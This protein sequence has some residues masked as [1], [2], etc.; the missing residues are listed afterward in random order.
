MQRYR[1]KLTSEAFADRDEV[2][3]DV[4]EQPTSKPGPCGKLV[5]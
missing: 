5:R 4:L 3:A 1:K 2:D